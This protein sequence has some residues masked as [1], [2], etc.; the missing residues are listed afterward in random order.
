MLARAEFRTESGVSF[1]MDTQSMVLYKGDRVTPLFTETLPTDPEFLGRFNRTTKDSSPKTLRISL[2]QACNYSCNYCS[3][4]DLGDPSERPPR[5]ATMT[6]MDQLHETL[7][8]SGLEKIEL[9]GGETLLYWPDILNIMDNLDREGL[10]WYIPTNGTPLMMKHVEYLAGLKGRV[11]IGISHDGPG[12][13][14]LRGKEFL[15]KKVEVLK[16]IQD[17]QGKVQFSLNP[18]ISSTNYDLMGINEFFRS[19]LD[20]NGLLPVSLNFELCRAYGDQGSADN[21]IQNEDLLTYRAGL[22]KYLDAHTEQ[23]RS[24]GY[25][26]EGDLLVTN[27][28]HTG[29]G[30]IPLAQ[31]FRYE[32]FPVTQ[33]NCGVDD[34]K[35]LSVDLD[36][37]V[38]VCQNTDQRYIK[39]NLR[40]L[41]EV[42]MTGVTYRA[43]GECLG[44]PV[45]R[46]CKG[47]CPIDVGPRNFEINHSVE[48]AHYSEI[49]LSALSL[50]FSSRVAFADTPR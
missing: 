3:Q 23:F 24:K 40:D 13:E 36:G 2:G 15:H 18:V 38:K 1:F 32:T 17:T 22:R 49:L 28:F 33:T 41:K 6:F 16:A 34:S 26:R 5:L 4:K 37:S 20:A 35:L 50:L 30:V 29:Q 10:T 7:N 43:T 42:V 14:A 48:W 19:F 25:T 9:W 12:H 44:C 46:L 27:L 45:A 11:G 47:S 21:V 8:L 39:G 31:S